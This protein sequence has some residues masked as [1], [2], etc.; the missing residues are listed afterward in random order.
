MLRTWGAARPFRR[1]VPCPRYMVGRCG[2]AMTEGPWALGTS[3][4][5]KEG[6]VL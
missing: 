6:D 2:P 4:L 1:H 5:L 3:S